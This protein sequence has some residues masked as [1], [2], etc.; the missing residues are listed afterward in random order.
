MG[1]RLSELGLA[2][3]F[4]GD[5]EA[6]HHADRSFRSWCRVGYDYGH[7]DVTFSENAATDL[8]NIRDFFHE[9]NVLQR[10]LVRSMPAG[11]RRIQLGLPAVTAAAFGAEKLRAHRL[12]RLLLSAVY[13]LH[14]YSGV[15]DALGS[16]Q[17]FRALIDGKNNTVAGSAPLMPWLVLEQ[18]LG[19][20]THSKN[21]QSL[22]PQIEDVEPAFLPVAFATEGW[23]DGL[24]I[25]KNWTLR[26]GVRA[27][28]EL[29]RERRK[30]GSLPDALF[31][32]S[33]V[34]AVLITD[35]LR[36]VPSVVSLDATP[37]QYDALGE[38]YD[39]EPGDSRVESAK[40]A[41][42]RRCYEAADHLVCLL[43]TSPSP[44]DA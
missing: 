4:L 6:Y 10:L 20:I 41:L 27:R 8:A 35:W 23:Q 22:V 17:A 39:H 9:R 34:P 29:M 25:W 38:F 21:L 3:R 28:L 19:H 30:S 43:Y 11:S 15:S 33:Q 18:T 7:N 36:R 32:H 12:N 44:R 2:F 5:A 31:V 37:L 40:T 24:P 16:P 14:Y 42:N 13:G 26:A 1:R